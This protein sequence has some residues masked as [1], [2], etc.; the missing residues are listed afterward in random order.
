[1]F[2]SMVKMRIIPVLDL[3]GGQ[4]VHGIGGRREEY[5]PIVS[6]LTT[7]CLPADVALA[8]RDRLGLTELYLADL[9][10][11]AGAAP[12]GAVYADLHSLGCRLWVDAG[13]RDGAY[14]R[15]VAAEGIEKVVV[16]LET[17]D[18]PASLEA[19]CNDLGGER[20]IFS[21]DLKGGRP[22]VDVSAW[23]PPDNFAL[24]ARAVAAGVRGVIVLDLARVGTAG[25]VGTEDLCQR[26]AAA[27]PDIEVVAGGGVRDVTDLQRLRQCGVRAVLVASALHDGKLGPEHLAGW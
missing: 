13:V 24:A 12:A 7:S 15:V 25:G 10:A 14:A 16:G 5:R 21:L 2:T 26:L 8:F 1:M 22:L 3:K 11:I 27:F 4:V 19:I 17:V 18:G 23:G 20:V 9:D 6:Q